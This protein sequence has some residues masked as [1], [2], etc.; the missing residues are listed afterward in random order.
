MIKHICDSC[1]RNE[2]SQAYKIQKREI[3]KFP[4]PNW[5]ATGMWDKWEEAEICEECA[6]WLLSLKVKG[7]T[8]D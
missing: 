6:E 4:I 8:K 5:L 3:L 7:A 1:K 2:A